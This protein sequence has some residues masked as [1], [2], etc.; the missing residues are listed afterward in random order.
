M[1]V[2]VVALRSGI[3]YVPGSRQHPLAEGAEPGRLG[4]GD[5]RQRLNLKEKEQ[6]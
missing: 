4:T 6:I 3:L 5:R 2:K 1:L